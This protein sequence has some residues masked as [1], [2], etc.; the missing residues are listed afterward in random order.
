LKYPDAHACEFYF[1]EDSKSSF[2]ILKQ[3]QNNLPLK[4]IRRRYRSFTGVV[5]NAALFENRFFISDWNAA[6]MPLNSAFLNTF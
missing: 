1:F 6:I 4:P 3:A 5:C 2:Q